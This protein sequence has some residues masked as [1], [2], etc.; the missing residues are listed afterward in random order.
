MTKEKHKKWK[1]L[2]KRG[3]RKQYF[4]ALFKDCEILGRIWE[5]QKTFNM[6]KIMFVRGSIMQWRR[7]STIKLKSLSSHLNLAIY[8]WAEF[9]DSLFTCQIVTR[10]NTLVCGELKECKHQKSQDKLP[11]HGKCCEIYMLWDLSVLLLW[12]LREL[13]VACE[14]IS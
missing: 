7:P 13:K 8:T 10:N 12:H 5:L 4:K 3:G 9:S 2:N 6:E 11:V 1:V 14:E